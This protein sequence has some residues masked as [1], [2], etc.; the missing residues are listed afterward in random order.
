LEYT[1]Q[2]SN[3]ATNEETFRVN[4]RALY[5]QQALSIT[6]YSTKKKREEKKKKKDKERQK[7]SKA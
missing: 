5:S 6:I 1:K 3:Q 7:A 4:E 2:Q